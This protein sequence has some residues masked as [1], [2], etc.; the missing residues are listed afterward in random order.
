[1]PNAHTA[2]API[3]RTRWVTCTVLAALLA[4][5]TLWTSA[6][7]MVLAVKSVP[8]R[9]TALAEVMVERLGPA[10]PL[11][12]D[13]RSVRY[14]QHD[15]NYTPNTAKARRAIAAYALAPVLVNDDPEE[16]LIIADFADDPALGE[17]LKAN[18]V[19]LIEHLGP[20]LGLLE[21]TR[22]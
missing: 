1:M 6:S 11:L 4:G 10:L 16:Q 8:N 2:T 7:R 18:P 19:R 9:E 22:P 15:E 12:Q 5:L 3:N 21:V 17:Y 20:G 13:V 14:V